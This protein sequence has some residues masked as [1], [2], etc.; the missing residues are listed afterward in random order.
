MRGDL[1]QGVALPYHVPLARVPR[2]GPGALRR[3]VL[4][5]C[6]SVSLVAH[7]FVASTRR[8]SRESR[9]ACMDSDG[10]D[11]NEMLVAIDLDQ[12]RIARDGIV[13]AEEA[14]STVRGFAKTTIRVHT[15]ICPKAL[16]K[17]EQ[18]MTRATFVAVTALAL[19]TSLLVGC[20]TAPTTT[21]EKDALVQK[22][23][24]ERAEWNR[25]DPGVEELAKKS[26]GVALFPEITKGGLGLGGSYGRGVV[27]ER[28]RHI[29]YADVTQAS[30]GLQAGGQIYSEVIVFEDT[31]AMERFKQNEMNFGANASA[32]IA[33]SGAAANARFVDGVAVFVRPITGAMAEASIGGQRTTYVPK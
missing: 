19:T 31:A 22:A 29:G 24:A 18:I 20:S 14:E 30:L 3:L 32:I 12:S 16:S 25:V 23:Q 27:Y 5:R 2:I 26:E 28:G 1:A 33:D 15:A 21:A 17:K 11:R 9:D 4:H 7:G 10:R 8:P 6:S 13:I